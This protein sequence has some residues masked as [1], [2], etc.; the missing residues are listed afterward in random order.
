MLEEL[1][2]KAHN[3]P[4]SPGV[5]IFRGAD[6]G[7]IYVGKAVKLRNRVS[8]YFIGAHNLKTEAMISNIAEFEVII[9]NS[10]FEALV[11]ENSL[12]KYHMPKYNILL[13]DDKGYPYIRIDRRERYPRFSIASRREEDGAFYFGPYGG[14]GATASAIDAVCKALCLPTCSRKFPRDIGKER[15]CLNHHMGTCRAYC[16]KDA[17]EDEYNAS[18]SEAI[19]ILEGKTDKLLKDLER[20]MSTAAESLRFERAAEI[21]DRIKTISLLETR[22]HVCAAS[23]A[24]TDAIGFYRGEA[25]SVFVVLHYIGG[26]LL[27]KDLRVIESPVEDDAEAVSSIVRQYYE[28]RGIVPREV[29][30]PFPVAD[31]DALRQFLAETANRNIKL[32]VPQR[33]D[34]EKLTKTAAINARDEVERLTT[35][36]ERISKTAEWLQK[37][38]GLTALPERIEAFD[39][40]NTGSAD[41]VASN[42]VFLKGKPYKKDY[43]KFIIKTTDGQDDYRS[44]AEA[45]S[46]RFARYI[47]GDEKFSALPDVLFIDGGAAHA[48]VALGVL[49]ELGISVPVFGMVKDDR[50]RTRALVTPDGEEI[51][52]SGNPAAF[53]LVGTIQEETHRFAIEFHR[54]RHSKKSYASKLDAIP[55]VGEARRNTLLKMFGSVRAVSRA[56]FEELCSAVPKDTAAS[57]FGYF[58]SQ[59]NGELNDENN[60][61]NS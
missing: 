24:D 35:K 59:G 56:T 18:I 52:I 12:I 16:L 4:L 26:A 60:N 51:G 1:R 46:R 58:H 5:Y 21:R 22:Q 32:S 30:L 17:S 28:I 14:R 43:R 61:R 23:R 53:A 47:E 2:E 33:G 36:E 48:S 9:V 6:G 38:L 29:L 13:K 54:S 40:S 45:V 49:R 37:A 10:E 50:H 41:I 55:G 25:R 57:V 20:E 42:T 44:M 39:I 19:M 8:S 7:V 27:D 34:R 15:P 11:L 3:L 31:E